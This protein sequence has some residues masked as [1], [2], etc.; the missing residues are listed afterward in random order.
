MG[1]QTQRP[2][3]EN[4]GSAIQTVGP[5]DREEADGGMFSPPIPF[6]REKK[7]SYPL[8][9]LVTHDF[10]LLTSTGNA[11]EPRKRVKTKPHRFGCIEKHLLSFLR[12]VFNTYLFFRQEIRDLCW[13]V[14]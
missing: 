12:N 5:T 1:D 6:L 7:R 2:L 10:I 8:P 13:S 4:E 3:P 14:S 9:E 11:Q